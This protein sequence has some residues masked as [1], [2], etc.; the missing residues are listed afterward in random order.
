MAIA[1]LNDLL[2][3]LRTFHL[4]DAR[5]LEQLSAAISN[6]NIDPR[7]VL[8][9][10]I[11]QG[12]LTPYQVN[13]LS[14]GKSSELLLGSYVLLERLGEGGM[15]TVLERDWPALPTTSRRHLALAPGDFVPGDEPL[16]RLIISRAPGTTGHPISVPHHPRAI[17]CYEPLVE[18][19]LERHGAR[20]RFDAHS[21]ACA[22]WCQRPG[23]CLT[24]RRLLSPWFGWTI[25][26]LIHLTRH[27]ETAW[28]GRF[29]RPLR[30]LILAIR[31][32]GGRKSLHVIRT[33]A[34]R[35]GSSCANNST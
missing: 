29:E 34:V 33:F 26:P 4:L 18:V 21:V 28:L 5:Q 10:L 1:S 32:D 22:A 30:P 2:A 31:N 11:Q 23:N 20:P 19:A 9:K 12:W 14:Q 24:S 3:A 15:G 17:R 16:E 25:Q 6:P 7:S 27:H 13:Q 35:F 8:Q